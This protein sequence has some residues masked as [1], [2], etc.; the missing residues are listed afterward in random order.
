M[1]IDFKTL[2]IDEWQ[3]YGHGSYNRVY[4]NNDKQQILKILRAKHAYTDFPKRAVKLWNKINLDFPAELVKKDGKNYGWICPYIKGRQSTDDEIKQKLIEIFNQTGRIVTDAVSAKN[5]ITMDTRKVVC[6]DVGLAL[7]LEKCES[8]SQPFYRQRSQTSLRAWQAL[9]ADFQPFYK[10]GKTNYPD[11]VA[12]LK[13]LIFIQ[14]NRPDIKDVTFLQ[15]SELVK[16]LAKAYKVQYTTNLKNTSWPEATP[17]LVAFAQQRLLE[18][19]PKALADLQHYCQ[20][21]LDNYLSLPKN[22]APPTSPTATFFKPASVQIRQVDI[23]KTNINLAFSI[24]RVES[25]L[26]SKLKEFKITAAD[27]NALIDTL[28]SCLEYMHQISDNTLILPQDNF[29]QAM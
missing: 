17:D 5:F 26:Q 15:D 29:A 2:K 24:I 18:T 28:T 19:R 8:R 6:V 11:T 10:K 3:L 12:L 27:D 20:T 16:L 9:E 4:L 14:N 1:T 7:T 22:L 21:H 23:L 25:L 13:A